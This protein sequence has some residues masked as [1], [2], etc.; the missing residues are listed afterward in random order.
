[1]SSGAP[2]RRSGSVRSQAARTRRWVNA[3]LI[4]AALLAVL[5]LANSVRDYFRVWRILTIRQ[6][7][8]P[9]AA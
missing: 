5:L 8:Y 9:R 3:W 1:M 2:A 6:G 4:A 7:R